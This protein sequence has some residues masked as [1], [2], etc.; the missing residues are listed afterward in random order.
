[1]IAEGASAKG[2]ENTPIAMT[3]LDSFTAT[4]STDTTPYSNGDLLA[5]TQI[6]NGVMTRNGG[7]RELRSICVTDKSAQGRAIDILFLKSNTSL[8][9]ENAA[10]SLSAA[11]GLE[12]VGEIKIAAAD[13]STYGSSKKAFPVGWPPTTV[14]SEDNST[15]IYIAAVYRDASTGT[16]AADALTVRFALL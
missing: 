13:W 16:Y 3:V 9:T 10:V 1:M 6:I 12:I 11:G 2:S 4:L 14:M 7:C 8:G 5:D 15:D